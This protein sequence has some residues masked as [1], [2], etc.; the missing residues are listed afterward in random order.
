MGKVKTINLG[1][2]RSPLT[3]GVEVKDVGVEVVGVKV[4]VVIEV[5]GPT[6]PIPSPQA[7]F[8][9]AEYENKDNLKNVRGCTNLKTKTI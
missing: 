3:I 6:N 2:Y 1:I 5:V 7:I 8:T 9:L 4:A